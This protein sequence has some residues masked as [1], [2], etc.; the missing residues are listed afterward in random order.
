MVKG[1]STIN[2][3]SYVRLLK[4]C[5]CLKPDTALMPSVF[6]VCSG[7]SGTKEMLNKYLVNERNDE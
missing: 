1:T 4:T 5:L 6:P 7:V 3:F 2:T